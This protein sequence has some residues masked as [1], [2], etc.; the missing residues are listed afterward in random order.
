MAGG[1]CFGA[2]GPR[3]LMNVLRS[4]GFP[5]VEDLDTPCTHLRCEARLH[6]I[7]RR[8]LHPI[9]RR[10]LHPIASPPDRQNVPTNEDESGVPQKICHSSVFTTPHIVGS[11]Q[12]VS[13]GQLASLR[14]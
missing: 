2:L 11:S 9:A 1:R 5:V 14:A 6:P 3:R 4:L 8:V 12:E 13:S 10:A 7:A